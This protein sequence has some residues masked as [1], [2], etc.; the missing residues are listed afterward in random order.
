VVDK[1]AEGES[2]K[3]TKQGKQET[4]CL[5]PKEPNLDKSILG[6]RIKKKKHLSQGFFEQ[7]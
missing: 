6:T 4:R 1:D 3:D 2:D 7:L 5:P